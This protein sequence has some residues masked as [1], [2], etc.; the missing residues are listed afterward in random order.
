M[1]DQKNRIILI[2]SMLCVFSLAA[3]TTPKK[4]VLHKDE[5]GTAEMFTYAVPGAEKEACEASRRALLSQGY[6]IS[7]ANENNVKARRKFQSDD[8]THVEI[9]F[10]VVCAPNS[11]GSNSTTI[12]ANAVRDRYS[13][14]K[15]TN[16]ASL[17]VGGIGSIS[18]PFGASN[19]SMVKVASETISDAKLYGRFFDLVERYLD[20]VKPD[21]EVLEKPTTAAPVSATQQEET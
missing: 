17:G 10:N 2:S 12:F 5:F 7:G 8:E 21:E 18:L 20:D 4:T 19:D 15:N 16:S 1:L 6:I 13:L 11:K 9:E 14:K 3:C